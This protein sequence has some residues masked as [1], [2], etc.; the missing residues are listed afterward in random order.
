MR[1]AV[2]I[3]ALLLA[4][5]TR[6]EAQEL[7]GTMR[8]ASGGAT[9]W[10]ASGVVIVAERVADDRPVART[11]T[12]AAGTWRLRVTT[13]S[14]RIRALRIGQ[15]PVE[16]AVLRLA[17]GASR[18]LSAV[19]PDR[20]VQISSVVTRSSNRCPSDPRN[21]RRVARLFADARTALLAS[22]LAS[23]DGRP[24]SRYRLTT[25]EWNARE[26]RLL[27]VVARES[28]ADSVNPFRSVPADS[29]ALIG[30]VTTEP[31]RTTIW[32]APD[33]AV[34]TD[35]AFLAEYC[36]S[37]VEDSAPESD[38]I[39]VG[40]RPAR[41]RRDIV[42]IEGVLW[43]DRASARLRRLDFH[44]V[45]LTYLLRDAAPRG[46]LLFTQLPE[47][48]W[49]VHAWALRM[50]VVA[51]RVALQAG[52]VIG[53]EAL[54]GITEL[55]AEVLDVMLGAQRRDTV[56]ATDWIDDSGAVLSSPITEPRVADCPAERGVVLGTVRGADAKPLADARV[57]LRSIERTSDPASEAQAITDSA[58]RYLVCSVERDALLLAR[59]DAEGHRPDSVSMRVTASRGIAQ[60]DWLLRSSATVAVGELASAPTVVGI[61]DPLIAPRQPGVSAMAPPA[62]V[63]QPLG[64]RLRV[65]DPSG[66]AV[67][68]ASVRFGGDEVRRSDS[69]GEVALP[70]DASLAIAVRISCIG[71]APYDDTLRRVSTNDPFVAVLA[72]AAPLAPAGTSSAVAAR[73]RVVDADS[74]PIP[75]A[76]VSVGGRPAQA[77]NADGHV[78]L[79]GDRRPDW[80][81]RVQ[82]I[83]YRPYDGRLGEVVAGATRIVSLAPIG[84]TLDEVRTIAPRETMLSRTRFYDRMERL[85]SGAF[86]GEFITPEELELRAV[87]RIT[88]VLAGKPY[89]RVANGRLF[90]R[91]GCPMNIFLDGKLMEDNA[92]DEYI[93][94]QAVMAI[95]IYPSTA[96]APAELIPVT[97]NGSCGIVAFWTGPRR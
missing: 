63:E 40:F 21:A 46:H 56:G 7:F 54:R 52:T 38:R 87:G 65:Q 13:D 3:A 32:R 55:E 59:F 73:V 6:L 78:P 10:P 34:L 88:S 81:I 4:A 61:A 37:L 48:P 17:D 69:L 89:V 66:A 84:T 31:D 90:G 47:G 60:I 28:V 39:G 36:L 91:G 96:N 22:Q 25:T 80:P 82:R 53:N 11:I 33:A 95:E 18:D 97:A 5:S 45:G 74:V 8:R 42:Q 94:S 23:V 85:R 68:V 64:R 43:L 41:S 58:G 14:L 16:L 1:L 93:G 76:L 77:A 12:G 29:L 44:Y 70:D 30:F 57:R 27:R 35:D 86:V 15:E 49:L 24:R 83:G 75:F 72:P 26:D 51:R 50:P 92:P 62:L 71:F 67:S 19:L 79:P 20:P 9:M 2:P